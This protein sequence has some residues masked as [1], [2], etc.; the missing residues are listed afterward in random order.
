MLPNVL[1]YNCHKTKDFSLF[2]DALRL[3]IK[4]V[5][6]S[7][8]DLPMYYY[9]IPGMTG[10]ACKSSPMCH[11]YWQ[12]KHWRLCKFL[13]IA[14]YS[15]FEWV[16]FTCERLTNWL[17]PGHS[18]LFSFFF[19]GGS[20]CAKWDRADDPLISG[21]EIQ[22]DRPEGSWTVCLLQSSP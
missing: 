15:I 21:S 1:L 11:H 3:F 17:P 12:S 9:H 16:R 4:E 19:S 7:A 22:W 18:F 14:Q 20:W 2:T 5:S 10:V 8:P 6:A 13:S